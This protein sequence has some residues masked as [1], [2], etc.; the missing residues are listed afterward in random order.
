MAATAMRVMSENPLGDS[1]TPQK[2]NGNRRIIAEDPEW[3]LAAIERLT[4]LCL[5]MIVKNFESNLYRAY[6]YRKSGV[7][8]HS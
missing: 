3:N 1:A 8:W 2:K 6:F 7:G 4:T 5:N